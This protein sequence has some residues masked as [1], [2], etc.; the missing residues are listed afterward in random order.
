LVD[1]D[2]VDRKYLVVDMKVVQ[3]DVDGGMRSISGF[4]I[5][6]VLGTSLRG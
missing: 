3:R 4:V 2:K 1:F 6:E 5:E